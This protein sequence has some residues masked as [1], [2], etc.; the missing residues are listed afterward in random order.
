MPVPRSL[1]NVAR[2]VLN[3]ITD[4]LEANQD[5]FFEIVL[6]ISAGDATKAIKALKDTAA[7]NNVAL[8]AL[9]LLVADKQHGAEDLL[10]QAKLRRDKSSH[11]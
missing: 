4:A 6:L 1:G 10:I 3:A 9:T 8:R 7:R 5:E 11:E 2:V